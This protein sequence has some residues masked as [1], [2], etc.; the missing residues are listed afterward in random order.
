MNKDMREIIRQSSL[1]MNVSPEGFEQALAFGVLRSVEEDSFFFM[2]NDP[3]N[4]CLCF[5]Q[6]A[7]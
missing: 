2:Q 3:A 7:G 6:R 1:I 5:D 4:P